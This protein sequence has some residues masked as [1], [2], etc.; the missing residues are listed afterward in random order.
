MKRQRYTSVW[1]AIEDDPG[2]RE[3][4]KLRSHLMLEL[5]RHIEHEGLSQSEAAKALGVSQPRISNLTRGK[6]NSFGLDQLVKM[7]TKA[8]LRVSIKVKKAA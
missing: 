4:L 8:G 2:L 5:T 3:N 7:A 6:I 1:D